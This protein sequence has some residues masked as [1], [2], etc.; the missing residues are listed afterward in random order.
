MLMMKRQACSVGT[1]GQVLEQL[2]ALTRKIAVDLVMVVSITDDPARRL[3]GYA[4]LAEAAGLC[5][6]S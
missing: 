3:R 1:A 6:A 5:A 4:R 2:R